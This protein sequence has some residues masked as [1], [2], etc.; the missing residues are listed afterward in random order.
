M[1][2]LPKTHALRRSVK[3]IQ[4]YSRWT[5]VFCLMSTHAVLG[6][7]PESIW[8]VFIQYCFPFRYSGICLGSR[9]SVILIIYYTFIYITERNSCV[10][11]PALTVQSSSGNNC[12]DP[13][14]RFN[15]RRVRSVCSNYN[16]IYNFRRPYIKVSIYLYIDI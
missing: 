5:A 10:Y 4:M 8:E 6:R 15:T 7:V 14:V 9:Y 13:K 1:S 12:F 3:G 2:Y 16:P 11:F